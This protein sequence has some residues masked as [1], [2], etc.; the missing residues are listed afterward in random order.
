MNAIFR[1]LTSMRP[2]TV[3]DRSPLP[4]VC[5]GE[6]CHIIHDWNSYFERTT[7]PATILLVAAFA[8]LVAERPLLAV[9]HH[10]QPISADPEFHQIIPHGFGALFT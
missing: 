3:H 8:A 9:G 7:M 6:S 5:S 10:R 1:H 2:S 4:G